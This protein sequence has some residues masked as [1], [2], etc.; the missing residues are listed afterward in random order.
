MSGI[1]IRMRIPA[2]FSLRARTNYMVAAVSSLLE[3]RG[4]RYFGS[5]FRPIDDIPEFPRVIHVLGQV[6]FELRFW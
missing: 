4:Q 1:P 2:N 3:R 5:H 6:V